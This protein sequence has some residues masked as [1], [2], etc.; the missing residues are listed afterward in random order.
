MVESGKLRLLEKVAETQINIPDEK[1]VEMFA[2]YKQTDLLVEEI[3]NLRLKHLPSGKLTIEKVIKR[4]DKDRFSSLIYALWYIKTF[5]ENIYEQT[6]D[7][8]SFVIA[9]SNSSPW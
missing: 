6:D 9:G 8:T 2:P 5:E 4:Y 3:A 7:W 1:A